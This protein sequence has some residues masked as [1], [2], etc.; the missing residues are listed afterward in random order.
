MAEREAAG[1]LPVPL[2]AFGQSQK[3]DEVVGFEH[4]LDAVEGGEEL[5]AAIGQGVRARLL[6]PVAGRGVRG[7]GPD[8]EQKGL[9]SVEAGVEDVPL[10]RA[11][12]EVELQK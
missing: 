12:V 11:Q 1:D 9:L 10:R 3:L 6:E 4:P 2:G 7:L 8:D 5:Q